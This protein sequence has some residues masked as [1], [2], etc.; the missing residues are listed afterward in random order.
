MTE[1]FKKEAREEVDN[2][3]AEINLFRE[4]KKLFDYEIF[5]DK[6]FSFQKNSNHEGSSSRLLRATIDA[7]SIEKILFKFL[8]CKLLNI[9]FCYVT[10][11]IK[12]QR[13]SKM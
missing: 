13:L 5:K 7:L 2:D 4:D 8:I 1:D 9:K 6:M 10:I 12:S 3:E 11:T